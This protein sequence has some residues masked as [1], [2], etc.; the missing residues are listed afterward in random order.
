MGIQY[1]RRPYLNFSAR[2]FL[3]AGV[4]LLLTVPMQ[5]VARCFQFSPW[6]SGRSPPFVI[7]WNTVVGIAFSRLENSTSVVGDSAFGFSNILHVFVETRVIVKTFGTSMEDVFYDGWVVWKCSP[8]CS[9]FLATFTESCDVA[10]CDILCL[11]ITHGTLNVTLDAIIDGSQNWT[12]K[13]L[14]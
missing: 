3:P 5:N 6:V 4:I 10:K 7:F 13:E 14:T 11:E 2:D 8:V 1:F 12:R 9:G